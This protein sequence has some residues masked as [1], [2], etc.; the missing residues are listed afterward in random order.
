M[1]WPPLSER[2][3]RKPLYRLNTLI[4]MMKSLVRPR[5]LEPPL[6]SQLAPQASASTNSAMAATVSL[7]ASPGRRGPS[8]NKR[9][10]GWQATSAAFPG[11]G[12]PA[13]MGQCPTP[14]PTRQPPLSQPLR[15]TDTAGFLP[16]AGSPPVEWC[17]AP[18]PVP[19]DAAVAAM[20]RH[21]A[22]IIA[23]KARERV[24][25]IE[26]PPLYTAGTSARDEDL[27]IRAF[28]YIAPGGAGSIPITGRG[29]GWPMPCSTST[30]AGPMSAPS[31]RRSRP[32]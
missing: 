26:H 16:V 20:E 32:G 29:S 14:N 1:C 28:R 13:M 10:G 25:L 31:W 27:R 9:R 23:G 6:V 30:G 12:E 4:V 15:H 18:A 24:W 17:V 2:D 5:G 11:Q 19:Y 21:V 22:A 8:P 7:R 3:R